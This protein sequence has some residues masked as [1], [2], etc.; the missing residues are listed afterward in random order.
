MARLLA[1]LAGKPAP[2]RAPRAARPAPGPR[3]R[4]GHR[5]QPEPARALG[6]HAV[7]GRGARAH[8]LRRGDR[9]GALPHRPHGA[10]AAARRGL[11]RRR[12]GG[13]RPA[14]P[15]IEPGGRRAVA[16]L[17]LE[18][19]ATARCRS[20][21]VSPP[22]TTRRTARFPLGV[23]ATLDA[24]AGTLTFEPCV[25]RWI[26]ERTAPRLS[27]SAGARRSAGELLVAGFDGTE[28]S[29]E[30]L[31]LIRAGLG[32][33]ILYRKNCVDAAQ[34]L[35]L[36]NRLQEA[37]RAAGHAQPLL[38]AIDQEQGRVVRLT[39]GVTVFPAMGA[40]ARAGDP[41]L[42]ERVAAAT[43]RELLA[44]GVNWNLAPVA[45]VLSRPGLPGRR[46]QLR[47]RSGA[48]RAA[49]RGLRA[50]RR[51]RR[52]AHLRQAL[53]RPRLDRARTATSPRRVVARS[54]AELDA[55]DLVPFRAAD[56]GRRPRGDDRAHHLPGARPGRPGLALAAGD[57]RAA[58]RRSWASPASSSR[59]TSRWPA[60]ALNH[61][62]ES[63]GFAALRAGS[64]LL[65]RLAHAPGRALHPRAPGRS[66]PR[67]RG[68]DR[69]DGD[70]RRR[71]QAR[72]PLQDGSRAGTP[73]RPRP[74]PCCA[75]PPTW[76]CSRRSNAVPS[77]EALVWAR[78]AFPGL[79][80]ASARAAAPGGL[81][82]HADAPVSHGRQPRA[83]RE[84]RARS[85]PAV[86]E[87]DAFGYLAAHL[88]A[89]GIPVPGVLAYKRSRGWSLVEDLGDRDLFAEVRRALHGPSRATRRRGARAHRRAL[90]RG[91]RR[92]R[93]PAGRRRRGL[94]P[95][96]HPQPAALRRR[97]DAG[98]GVRL[99]RA[100]TAR[101]PPRPGGAARTGRRTRPPR[102]RGPPRPGPPYLL[103]RD[104]QSQNLKIHLGRICVIDFQGARLGPPQYDLAALLLDPYADLPAELRAR[105]A[106]ALSRRCSPRAPART[107]GVS[108]SSSPSS[109]RT[110]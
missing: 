9:R 14:S 101:P 80:P 43:S 55:C 100:R 74:A 31:A 69:P 21:R 75:P 70:D 104:Y 24:D 17:F 40:I 20:S 103:H 35:E 85:P 12:R 106:R 25:R 5:R 76:A 13:P 39:E 110:G 67:D 46:P 15:G 52:D 8:P 28:P 37:A 83:R 51:G 26:H 29:K 2:A 105:I 63:A 73:T 82:A 99:F 32:G 48:G 97:A 107:A 81:L 19:W 30:I 42:V 45:D 91:A 88:G 62:L 108:S 89:R 57:R 96:P 22:G 95:A 38:I 94:R 59:T 66:A 34:V 79:D 71:A 53:P 47:H 44:V 93:A 1:L 68:R 61:S 50:R 92:P 58:A 87:N 27:G 54:R 36:T 41:E 77:A 18:A 109:P 11:P 23:P 84:P 102:R 49:G 60:I 64:D 98:G 56:R 3:A 65:H 16:G 6:R 72:R 7:P 4:G 86:N 78:R 10:P 33:V 90:P